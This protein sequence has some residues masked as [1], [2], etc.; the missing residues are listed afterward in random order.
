VTGTTSVGGDRT[1]ISAEV[2]DEE[3]LRYAIQLRSLAAGTGTFS[4]HYL[5]HEAVPA[6]VT[7][8]ALSR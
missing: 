5:R 3:L 7:P 8:A 6:N 4:R 1:E 2:P